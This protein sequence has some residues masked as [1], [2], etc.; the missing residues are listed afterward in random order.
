MKTVRGML[1]RDI[2]ASVAFVALAF[3]S[4]SFFIDFVDDMQKIGRNGFTLWRAVL[5]SLLEV[6]GN[7]YELLPIAVLIGTIYSLARLAQTSE[8]TILRTGGLS[9]G[10]ALS[11]LAALA[12]GFSALTFAIGDYVVPFSERQTEL[13]RAALGVRKSGRAGAWLK[14][15]RDTEH[16]ERSYTVNVGGIDSKGIP[17]AS[18]SSSSTA[19]GATSR[20]SWRGRLESARAR[21]G[22]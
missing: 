10:R 11:L 18:A 4:L 12:L 19:T 6:P 7:L 22:A 3:V 15:R 20:A 9:P 5:S 13:I 1:Y 17:R 21:P 8:F 2:G 14:E 16:G